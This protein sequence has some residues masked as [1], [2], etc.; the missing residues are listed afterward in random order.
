MPSQPDFEVGGEGAVFEARPFTTNC[1]R[2]VEK[3]E[4]ALVGVSVGNGYFSQ[5]RIAQLLD[6]TG[7]R[8]ASVDVL[9]ADLHVESAFRASGMDPEHAARRTHRAL[10]DVRRRIRRAVESAGDVPARVRTVALSEIAEFPGY[11][12][13]ARRIDREIEQNPLLRAACEDH[14]RHVLGP[15]EDPEGARFRAGMDYLRAELP[16]LLSSPEVLDVASSVCCYHVLMPVLPRLR[17]EASCFH[18][19]QGHLVLRPLRPDGT[20]EDAEVS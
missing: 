11:R 20:Y 15:A 19:R 4:H 16:F 12:T 10:R 9:Y 6:W 18:P 7:R 14:V 1:E 17:G 2:L 13:A 8:F 5:Y 3:G